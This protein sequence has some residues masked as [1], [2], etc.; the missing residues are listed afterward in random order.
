MDYGNISSQCLVC[1]ET[2]YPGTPHNFCLEETEVKSQSQ[3]IFCLAD[4]R[5]GDHSEC[6][7]RIVKFRNELITFLLKN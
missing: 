6:Q 3:C 7:E 2:V 4:E 1:G 5:V